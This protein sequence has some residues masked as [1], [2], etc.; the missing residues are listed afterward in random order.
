MP[1]DT[2]P[3]RRKRARQHKR[4]PKDHV[5]LSEQDRRILCA[6]EGIRLT[7]GYERRE[8]AIKEAL[9]R[10]GVP[11]DQSHKYL[12]RLRRR[13]TAMGI[14]APRLTGFPVELQGTIRARRRQAR[15]E[16]TLIKIFPADD[17]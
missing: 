17:D 9:E 3:P 16:I 8:P 13:L 4:P 2:D 6:A 15:A 11:V 10:E 14:A 12:V 7:K 5:G 1:R